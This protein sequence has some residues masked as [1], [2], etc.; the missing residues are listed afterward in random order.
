VNVYGTVY[1]SSN[2]NYNVTFSYT[3]VSGSTYL[4]SY[5]WSF[6]NHNIYSSWFYIY[7]NYDA[8][9]I[10]SST[11][12]T[13]LFRV[14]AKKSITQSVNGTWQLGNSDS[15]LSYGRQDNLNYLSYYWNAQYSTPLITVY[16]SLNHWEKYNWIGFRIIRP[17]NEAT[18]GAH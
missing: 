13:P 10:N 16:P 9:Q 18:D 5:N 12:S 4:S 15:L 1:S 3:P 7:P 17:W 8:Q 6:T 14:W 2:Y 11:S